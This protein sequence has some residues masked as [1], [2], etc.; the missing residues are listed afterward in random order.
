M[1]QNSSYAN[2][3][4][5]AGGLPVLIPLQVQGELLAEL[6]QRVDGLIFSGGGDIDPAYYGETPQVANLDEVQPGRDKLEIELMRLATRQHKPFLAICRGIQVMNVANGGSLWQD[7]A[8]QK[9]QP[10]RHDYYRNH[11]P[12]NY[13]A[14]EVSL[15]AGSLLGQILET[16]R[17]PVNSLHHQGVKKVASPLKA[18]GYA[19]DGLVEVLEVRDHPFGLGVQWH[20]EELVADQE[21]ARKMFQAFVTAARN[22]HK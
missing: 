22:G 19:P 21:A 7:V 10:I 16:G 14:H 15:E 6:L 12:R 9:P 13:L 3:V 11:H 4:I 8:S 17:L 18:A 1:A 5:Q 2:A 20:P